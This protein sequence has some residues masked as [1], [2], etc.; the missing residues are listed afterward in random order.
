[1]H[2]LAASKLDVIDAKNN[3]CLGKIIFSITLKKKK[4]GNKTDSHRYTFIRLSACVFCLSITECISNLENKSSIY[5]LIFSVTKW[6]SQGERGWGVE[7]GCSLPSCRATCGPTI[8]FALP[9]LDQI[10][11]HTELQKKLIPEVYKINGSPY[12]SLASDFHHVY[13]LTF[14]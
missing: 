12:L 10:V 3:M 9:V 11:D 5:N 6:Q 13:K 7:G 4:Q 1:M 2:Y 8:S 14:C